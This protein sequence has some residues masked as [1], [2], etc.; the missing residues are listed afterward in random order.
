MTVLD[1]TETF[2]SFYISLLW[3]APKYTQ[4]LSPAQKRRKSE[5]ICYFL[6]A[7]SE[8][9]FPA[10]RVVWWR[11]NFQM[12]SMCSDNHMVLGQHTGPNVDCDPLVMSIFLQ[13]ERDT[14]PTSSTVRNPSLA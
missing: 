9:I 13:E 14:R 11:M 6:T 4:S 2:N 5:I 10:A 8:I 3:I 7:D 1:H 12:L